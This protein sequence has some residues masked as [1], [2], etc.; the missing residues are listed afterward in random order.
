MVVE[1]RQNFQFF[2]QITWYLG[3]N[4]A[5]SKFKCRILHYLMS[6]LNHTKKI[7]CKSQ[8]F[9]NHASHLKL[10]LQAKVFS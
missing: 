5:M 10:K 8:L 9:I 7:V 6:I 4:R 2:K 1:A 3:N